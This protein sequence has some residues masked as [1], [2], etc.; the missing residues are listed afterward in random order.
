L[1][2]CGKWLDVK[3]DDRKIERELYPQNRDLSS[4]RSPSNDKMNRDDSS[5]RLNGKNNFLKLK[6]SLK[7]LIL[8]KQL[9]QRNLLLMF[10]HQ[11]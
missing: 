1:F 8:I 11:T 10:L 9:D 6:I 7:N 3:E 4:E 2:P 5:E